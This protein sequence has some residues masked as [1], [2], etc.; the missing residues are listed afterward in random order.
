MF[1]K[2]SLN[3]HV[4]EDLMSSCEDFECVFIEIERVHSANSADHKNRLYRRFLR[5][6]YRNRLT[7]V[8]RAAKK[9]YFAQKLDHNKASLK[10]I[11]RE[12]NSIL[13]KNKRTD[14]PC[15]FTNGEETLR[16]P[17]EIANSFNTHFSNIGA[18]LANNIPSTNSHYTD[19]LHNPNSFSFFLT[20]TNFLEVI[21]IS[22]DLKS[23][24]SCGSDGI[25]SSVI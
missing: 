14:L 16:D 10:N 19:F 12:I 5:K 8:I 24:S 1:V 2:N 7:S 3:F 17:P 22:N 21:K 13:G 15:E 11:W 18:S 9:N 4:R 6:D 20:P 23:S 25:N